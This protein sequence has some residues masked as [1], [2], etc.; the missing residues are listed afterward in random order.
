[1]MEEGS[2]STAR[3]SLRAAACMLAGDARDPAAGGRVRRA[4]DQQLR[5]AGVEAQDA[6]DVRTEVVL[7][8][9]C[10]AAAEL[11]LPLELV[12]ARASA[13]A[14]NKAIDHGR[15]RA[16]A[17]L[18]FG[19]GSAR[20]GS[21]RSPPG[22]AGRRARRGR[23][24]CAPAAGARRPRAARSTVWTR[25]SARPSARTPRVGRRAPPGS[26]ARPTTAY[27]PTPR[28]GCA[29]ICATASTGVGALGGVAPARSRDAPACR[30]R[31]RRRC[32]RHGSSR[33]HR[34]R[35]AGRARRARHPLPAPV[36]VVAAASS[37]GRVAAAPAAGRARGAR[38]AR[39]SAARDR[40]C[41]ATGD[42]PARAA[43]AASTS[44]S[45]LVHL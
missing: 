7:A 32:C 31:A 25:R 11:P 41:A 10:A 45:E 4:V 12:C 30:G 2:N 14:R 34:R 36:P 42:A 8:L 28:L 6:D 9:L 13:I 22:L 15:R 44:A 43:A 29:A 38:G 20:A 23:G 1:M 27:S 24:S 26:R 18:A 33:D 21:G 37:G 19:D 35:R 40:R 16:R 5:R 39:A 17:P 3:L